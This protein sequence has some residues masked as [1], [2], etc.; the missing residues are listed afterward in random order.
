MSKLSTFQRG[1]CNR[2]MLSIVGHKFQ[3]I[4]CVLTCIYNV[5]LTC[6]S[7]FSNEN[8]WVYLR[9]C[10]MVAVKL[11]RK[12][13]KGPIKQRVCR[14]CEKVEAER[15]RFMLLEVRLNDWTWEVTSINW[16]RGERSLNSFQ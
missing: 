12:K 7:V 3:F 4:G 1:D 14:G 10:Y 2:F 13:R 8:M 5:Y 6:I 11:E 9:N 15:Y 16:G